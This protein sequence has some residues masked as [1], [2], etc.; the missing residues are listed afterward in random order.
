MENPS[1][2]GIIWI[3]KNRKKDALVIWRKNT[4]K[5]IVVNIGRNMGVGAADAVRFIP[6]GRQSERPFFRFSREREKIPEFY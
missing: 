6:E 3:G 1:K 4:S 5:E 2:P